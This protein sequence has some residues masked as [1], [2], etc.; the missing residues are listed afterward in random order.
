MTWEMFYL[1]CFIFGFMLSALSFLAGSLHLPHFHLH[2]HIGHGGLSHGHG[3]GGSGGWSWLN[4]P[5]I[6]AFIA[7]FGGTGFLAEHYSRFVSLVV[8]AIAVGGGLIGGGIVFWFFVKVLLEHD[9]QLDP[10]DYDMIGVLGQICSNVRVGGTGEMIYSQQGV[11]KAVAVRTED[12]T[13]IARGTEVIVTRYE[14]GIAY[15]GRWDEL[16]GLRGGEEQS[17]SGV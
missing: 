14:K 13:E 9:K 17:A 6:T 3:H 15:V 12:G 16:T 8:L 5:T 4:M 1:G 7:W 11:R 2:H 10:A